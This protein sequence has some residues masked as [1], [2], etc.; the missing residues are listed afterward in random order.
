M[1]LNVR[2]LVLYYQD[3]Q[4]ESSHQRILYSVKCVEKTKIKKK[5]GHLKNIKVLQF[6]HS[7]GKPSSDIN[8]K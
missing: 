7:Y 6:S 5:T 8:S 2:V 3:P 4:F 1:K